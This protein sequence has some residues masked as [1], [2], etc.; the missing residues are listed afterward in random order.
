PGVPI[1]LPAGGRGVPGPDQP[2]A[3][4]E[5]DRWRRGHRL[6]HTDLDQHPDTG[7]RAERLRLRP[8]AVV[9]ALPSG[10]ALSRQRRVPVLDAVAGPREGLLVRLLR[11]GL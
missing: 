3:V 6:V 8:R 7:V 11:S 2:S 4:V 5:A 9:L 10:S 1:A